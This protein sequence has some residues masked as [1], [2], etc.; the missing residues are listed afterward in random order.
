[1]LRMTFAVLRPKYRK[2]RGT[3]TSYS[4]LK[5]SETLWPDP[6]SLDLWE[7]EFAFP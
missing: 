6:L 1:M 2:Q 3:M 4:K 5:N 7:A